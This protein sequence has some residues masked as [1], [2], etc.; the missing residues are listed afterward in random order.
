MEAR[1]INVIAH[2]QSAASDAAA[3][4]VNTPDVFGFLK[5]VN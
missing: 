1:K 4:L 2:P 3:Q 5:E